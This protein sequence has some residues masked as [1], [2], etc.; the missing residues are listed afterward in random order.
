MNSSLEP[1]AVLSA[2]D[3]TWRAFFAGT[4]FRPGRAKDNPPGTYFV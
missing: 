1:F 4:S 3:K 2:P